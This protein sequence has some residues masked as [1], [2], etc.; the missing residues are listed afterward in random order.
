M[1]ESASPRPVPNRAAVG[2]HRDRDR[3]PIWWRRPVASAPTR[4]RIGRRRQHPCRPRSWPTRRRI[5]RRRTAS[6]SH[7]PYWMVLPFVLLLGAIAVLPLIP[8]ASHWWENNL[9][10]FYVA[11]GLAAIT[12][13]LLSVAA[14]VAHRR[15]IGR[16]RTSRCRRHGAELRPDRRGV[17]QRHP[18]RVHPVHRPA[19]QSVHDQRR[20]SHRGRPA[21]PSAD[22]LRVSGGRRRAGQFHR[23]H[24]RRDAA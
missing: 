4:H 17:G 7:P 1:S 20:H 10:R 3:R 6:A 19:V 16:R 14:R 21:G 12:L 13:G 5:N 2:G 22:Q 23:H 9:H 15:P 18:G 24:R 8:A 11:G